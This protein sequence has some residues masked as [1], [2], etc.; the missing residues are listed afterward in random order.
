MCEHRYSASGYK[1]ENSSLYYYHSFLPR[2]TCMSG[3]GALFDHIGNHV[4]LYT[5][6]EFLS[7][8]YNA[9]FEVICLVETLIT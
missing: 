3:A 7:C 5:T 4:L 1:C 9:D 2:Y 6:M 8:G